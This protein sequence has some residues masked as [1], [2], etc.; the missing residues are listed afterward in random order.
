M[1]ASSSISSVTEED[2]LLGSLQKESNSSRREISRRLISHL[3]SRERDDA[4]TRN[5]GLGPAARLIRDAVLGERSPVDLYQ[6]DSED[7]H[8]PWQSFVAIVCARLV[9]YRWINQVVQGRAWILVLLS[10]VDSPPWCQHNE[11][12]SLVENATIDGSYGTC[13]IILEA[14]GT[15]V[16]GTEDV[17]LYPNASSMW[18][19]PGQS[20]LVEGVCLGVLVLFM[21]LEFGKDG[22]SLERYFQPGSLRT[23]RSFR[24]V[25]T[26]CLLFR[27]WIKDTTYSPFF[28]LFLLGTYLKSFQKEVDSFIR[29]LPQAATILS[30]LVILIVFYGWFGVVI[31]YGSEQG[32]RD[33]SNLIEGCWT[34]WICVTTANYP[35]V[36]MPSY[37]NNRLSGLFFVSYMA[38]SYFLI[39]NLILA[40]VVNGYNETIERRKRVRTEI[41]QESLTQAFELLDQKKA[42]FIDRESIMALF[43]ILNE[44]FPEIR[45]LSEDETKLLFGFLDKDGSSRITQEEFL[46]FGSVL[47]L[48]F[49]SDAAYETLVQRFL[50]GIFA[51]KWYRKVCDIVRSTKF[52]LI[53]DFVLIA[54]AIIIGFQSYPELTGKSITLNS[55]YSDGHID[56][57]EELVETM[58]TAFYLVEALLKITVDGWK[59]YKESARNCFDFG[60]TMTALIATAY[61]YYPNTYSDSRL[62]RLVVMARVLRLVRLLMIVPAFQLLGAIIAEILPA[63]QNVILLL[64]FLMY[65]FAAL[66]MILYG[67]MITRDPA[68]PLSHAILGNAFSDNDYWAN[69]FNDMVSLCHWTPM[70]PTRTHLVVFNR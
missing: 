46:D 25:F 7:E 21:G 51:S 26:M 61:V 9:A 36:M 14:T 12:I 62:I 13:G 6:P 47:L 5:E 42:G 37:N 63:A 17:H 55:H 65:W 33:F 48:E 59:R 64:F 8:H 1:R 2:S 32:A 31:F 45:R 52:E 53:V 30:V 4:L 19:T 56:T 29:L 70:N 24:L 18:L 67:G 35:D 58:F 20:N 23:I 40:A 34:M 27:L 50:P 16:D 60:V 49:T 69:N 11:D 3:S 38:I 54:N 22:L 68:N 10:F 57:W 15:A 66:G 43:L 39:M 41:A 44:D 28:R